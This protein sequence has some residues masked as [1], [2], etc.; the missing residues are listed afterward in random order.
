MQKKKYCVLYCAVSVKS[1]NCFYIIHLFRKC[2]WSTSIYR[3][4]DTCFK[5]VR[6][7]L[8]C[9]NPC[10]KINSHP[11]TYSDTWKSGDKNAS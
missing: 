10:S 3:S 5:N 11:L 8:H 4:S 6:L 2:S 9:N 1:K 7:G